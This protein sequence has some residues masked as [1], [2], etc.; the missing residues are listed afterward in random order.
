MRHTTVDKGA[1]H[2]AALG[3]EADARVQALTRQLQLAMLAALAGN[4][5]NAAPYRVRNGSGLAPH[6]PA[7]PL[8]PPF[9]A[10]PSA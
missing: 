3:L 2:A 9:A 7:V 4:A 10:W 8:R 5:R 1:G 6:G